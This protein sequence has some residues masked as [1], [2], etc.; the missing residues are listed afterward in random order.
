M[1]DS[2][3]SPER[4]NSPEP[5]LTQHEARSASGADANPGGIRWAQRETS[6]ASQNSMSPMSREPHEPQG[7]ML[8]QCR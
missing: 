8:I 6:P 5:M 1:N 7:H 4:A 2:S 3:N